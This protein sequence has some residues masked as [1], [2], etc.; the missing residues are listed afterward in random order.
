MNRTRP[1]NLN[2]LTIRFPLPAII[3][4]LH[5]ISGA[6]LFLCIPLLLWALQYSLTDSGYETIQ[7]SL[8]AK[9]GLWVVLAA[10]IY[11][12]VAGIRHLLADFFQIGESLKGG[13]CSAQL[14]LIISIILVILAGI[15]LW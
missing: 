3:S 8:W 5:R 11:H 10:F 6:F 13:K 12:V 14:T 15:W 2:L 4:I 9:L 7:S 1:K